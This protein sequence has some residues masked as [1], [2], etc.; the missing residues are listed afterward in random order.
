MCRSDSAFEKIEVDGFAGA[1]PRRGQFGLGGPSDAI[2]ARMTSKESPKGSVLPNS[3]RHCSGKKRS[4]AV[5][6]IGM[7][8][9]LAKI[10]EM[11]RR[12]P[13]SLN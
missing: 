9:Q 13:S 2:R 10:A 12:A 4:A 5:K 8:V 1:S 3:N 7:T 6:V 11:V